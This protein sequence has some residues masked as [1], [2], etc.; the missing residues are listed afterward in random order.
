MRNITIL[1]ICALLCMSAA[2]AFEWN[3]D[4]ESPEGEQAVEL[5]FTGILPEGIQDVFLQTLAYDITVEDNELYPRRTH[6]YIAVATALDNY[7]LVEPLLLAGHAQGLEGLY[8]QNNAR[9]AY[10]VFA[11]LCVRRVDAPGQMCEIVG[12]SIGLVTCVTSLYC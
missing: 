8:L 10:G 7:E 3:Q 5:I 12:N 4:A 11:P 2:S 1:V 9:R 6:V